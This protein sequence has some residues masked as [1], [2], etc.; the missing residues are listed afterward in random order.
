LKTSSTYV[1]RT[2]WNEVSQENELRP[3][4]VV[5]VWS[6]WVGSEQKLCLTLVVDSRCG[7]NGSD[8][9]GNEGGGSNRGRDG[10][11]G[12]SGCKWGSEENDFDLNLAF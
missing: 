1:L 5:Q 4:D 2:Y 9:S 3:K 7:G 11:E 6:L 12:C 8:S 10:E